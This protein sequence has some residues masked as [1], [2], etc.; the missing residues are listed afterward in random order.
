MAA[1][2]TPSNTTTSTEELLK[3]LDTQ[4]QAYIE[5]FKLVH[6]ALLGAKPNNTSDTNINSPISPVL[7]AIKELRRLT[8]DSDKTERPSVLAPG[9]SS[10]FH[11]SILTGDSD[12]SDDDEDLYVQTPLPLAKFDHEDLKTH[13]KTY[14]F[15]HYGKMLLEGV[16]VNG[17]LL[18]PALFVKEEDDGKAVGSHYSVFDVG[19]DGAP[20][21]RH[22]VVKGAK[23]IDDAIWQTIR[24]STLGLG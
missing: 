10:T 3:R 12:S 1:P 2:G 9:K 21:S 11:S 7:P 19:G 4:H 18:N 5:T 17:R 15:D 24:V 23:S 22:D 20:L 8:L 13:L 14:K 16:L 6:E